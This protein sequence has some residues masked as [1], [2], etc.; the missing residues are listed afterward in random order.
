MPNVTHQ[1]CKFQHI[2]DFTVPKR[3]ILV[4]GIDDNFE[5]TLI[6]GSDYKDRNDVNMA[7]NDTR[8]VLVLI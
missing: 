8:E 4:S 1:L 2:P 6:A 5:K 3:H 7:G